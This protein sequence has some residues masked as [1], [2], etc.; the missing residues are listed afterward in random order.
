MVVA[1]LLTVLGGY[2]LGS[3]PTAVV[4][5]RR[6]GH[7][8]TAEGSGN[9]GASNVYRTAGRGAGGVVL[10]GDLAKGAVAAGAGWLLGDHLLGMA[11]GAAAVV[12]HVLPL[13]RVRHGGKGVATCAGV[14]LVL[15]PIVGVAGAALWVLTAKLSGRPSVASL[16][17]AAAVPAGAAALGAPATE[18]AVLLGI[19][20]LVVVRHGSN[21]ARLASGT[22]ARIGTGQR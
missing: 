19:G 11:C 3:L 2:L 20:V 15:H 13:G 12:G 6:L 1:A 16:L 21:I 14:V 8:P 7:D 9:P 10:A 22:E 17:L 5:G 18:V 4:V